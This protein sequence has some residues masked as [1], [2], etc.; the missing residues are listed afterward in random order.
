MQG[1]LLVMLTLVIP[2]AAA[3]VMLLVR[4]PLLRKVIVSVFAC[5]MIAVAVLLGINVLT[6]GNIIIKASSYE[7][8][9]P[10]VTAIDIVIL[11]TILY[12]G[13]KLREWKII[14]PSI[15]QAAAL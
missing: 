12:F 15:L 11:A 5:L 13:I 7:W 9:G 8:V 4:K 14:L 10:I 2:A 1:T 3:P 6:G